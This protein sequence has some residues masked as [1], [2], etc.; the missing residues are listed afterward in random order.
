MEHKA[1]MLI[2]GRYRLQRL[3]GEG[4]V[5]Q[6]WL[7]EDQRLNQFVALKLLRPQYAKDKKVLERFRR[8]ARVVARLDSPHIVQ[9]YDVSVSRFDDTHFI[10]ME[11][12]EGQDL[13][14]LLRFEAPLSLQRSLRLLRDITAGVAVA[15][16]MGLIHRDLK[17]GNVLISKERNIKITD[18]GIARYIAEVGLTEPGSVWGTSHYIAPEQASGKILST[19]TDIY[20]LGIILFEMLTGTL[21]YP[22]DDPVAVAVAHIQRPIPAIQDYVPSIPVGVANLVARMM[23]KE[24]ADR[25]ENGIVLLKI[26]E[27]Y[28]HDST[29]ATQLRAIVDPDKIDSFTE[30]REETHNNSHTEEEALKLPIIFSPPPMGRPSGAPFKLVSSAL[31]AFVGLFL[32]IVYLSSLVSDHPLIGSNAEPMTGP[33]EEV[34]ATFTPSSLS[35]ELSITPSQESVEKEIEALPPTPTAAKSMIIS[36]PRMN[37]GSDAHALHLK[38]GP[39]IRIDGNLSEWKSEQ[40]LYLMNP[41]FG[42]EFWTGQSDLTGVAHFAWDDDFLYL[43]V[44]RTDDIH[45]QNYATFD[46]YRGDSVELWIDVDLAGDFNIELINQDDFQFGFSPGDFNTR[47]AEGV[48]YYPDPRSEERNRQIGVRAEPWTQGYTLEAVI[49][50]SLLGIEPRA[51]LML[52]YVVVLNDNDLPDAVEIQ[53]QVSSNQEVPFQ[54]PLT[55]GNLI[56]QP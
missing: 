1:K 50:W 33:T 3:L 41:V 56:L 36:Q 44:L 30:G 20:S 29:S 38:T 16:E 40:P 12:V 18:F 48:V 19:A 8:E 24:P 6:V 43:A 13:K 17:P 11:Y 10:A 5:A 46:M 26:L 15:H 34:L 23:A 14:D 28:L 54:K 45:L 53:T 22:G 47:R 9:I 32:W 37:N 49:P 27:S 21:P 39:G 7:A 35:S 42:A 31:I 55:F 52:G 51:N 25:P 4:G 2:K